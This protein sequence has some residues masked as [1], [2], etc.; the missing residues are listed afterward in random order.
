MAAATKRRPTCCCAMPW[1]PAAVLRQKVA[2]RHSNG[3]P[4]L[5]FET[6]E[7]P[8]PER[9]SSQEPLTP[10]PFPE[11]GGSH[12]RILS[13]EREQVLVPRNQ[14][15]GLGREQ[16]FQYRRVR[17]VAQFSGHFDAGLDDLSQKQEAVGKVADLRRT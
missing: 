16:R 12:N 10:M 5:D 14:I 8:R 9:R 1:N 6:M 17:R 11:S 13:R 7:R 15:V 3:P 4:G 2:E